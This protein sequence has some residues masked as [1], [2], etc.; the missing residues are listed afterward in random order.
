MLLDDNNLSPAA[1]RAYYA[2]YQA[3]TSMLHQN[4]GLTRPVINNV[5]REGWR[6]D[7]TPDLIVDHSNRLPL[8]RRKNELAGKLKS[9]YR[10][11]LSAD[12]ISNDTVGSSAVQSALSDAGQ[13][14]KAAEVCIAKE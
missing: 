5:S 8:K 11:R 13:I 14:V 12:Y 2:A 3:A 1:S 6:H 10:L 4:G 9:L 7:Q